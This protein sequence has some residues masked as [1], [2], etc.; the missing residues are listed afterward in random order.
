MVD[1]GQIGH[2]YDRASDLMRALLDE[3][4]RVPDRPRPFEGLRPYHLLDTRQSPSGRWEIWADR[5]Q[6]AAIR[7]AAE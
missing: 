5:R 3:L 6:A 4:A 2:F 1:P 7:A